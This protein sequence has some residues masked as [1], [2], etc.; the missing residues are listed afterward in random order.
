MN[1]C[2][3]IIKYLVILVNFLTALVGLVVVGLAVLGLTAGAGNNLFSS[4]FDANHFFWL[5]VAILILGL[6]MTLI[7]FLGCT[8]ACRESQCLLG[9]FFVLL[10]I[11]LLAE[12]GG[13]VWAYQNRAELN[14]LVH[15]GLRETV[16][17]TVTKDYGK[18]DAATKALDVLQQSLKC[19]GAD[20]YTSWANSAYNGVTSPS[21]AATIFG[22][23]SVNY[24]IPKSCCVEPDSDTCEST[25]K[26]GSLNLLA[27]LAGV[28]Y[29]EGCIPKLEALLEEQKSYMSYA[30]G[31]GIVTAVIQLLSM[32]FSMILCCAIRQM[33]Y[34]G[35]KV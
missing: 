1:G 26:T 20:S 11:I 16:K 32:I 21:A 8:G 9:T 14:K 19:C 33:D 12:I 23:L 31:V 10:S 25:R 17:E 7:G 27:S 34:D 6:L 24:K 4:S 2:C 15:E 22:G 3:S 28:V 29:T 13:A 35:Y 30:V 18:D 5:C